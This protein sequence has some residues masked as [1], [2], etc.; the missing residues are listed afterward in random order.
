MPT[1]KTRRPRQRRR[2]SS[3][4]VQRA[5]RGAPATALLRRYAQAAA[6]AGSDVALRIVGSAESGKLNFRFRKKTGPTN[7]LSFPYGAG[8][9]DVVLCQPVI[10]REARKQGKSLRAHYAHLVVHGLL[11]LRG[12]AHLRKGDA[13]R[14]ERAEVRVLRRLGFGNPY[15]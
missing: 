13:S 2:R 15:E 1:K 8:S 11:H 5:A 3:V 4:V 6:P 12:H 10:A 7:V 14:M 9:G